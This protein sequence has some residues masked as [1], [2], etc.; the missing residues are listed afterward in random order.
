MPE[1]V[2]VNITEV[3]KVL[4]VRKKLAAKDFNDGGIPVYSS[5][6]Q[7]NGIKGYYTKAEFVIDKN[8]EN[9]NQYIVFGDHTRSINVVSTDFSV[10]DNVKVLVPKTE[11]VDLLYIKYAWQPKIPSLGYARHWSVAQSVN[12]D[13]PVDTDGN[14]DLEKQRDIAQKYKLI[15][16]KKETLLLKAEEA[17]DIDV[18]FD[19]DKNIKF[20]KVP[21]TKLFTPK[22]GSMKYSKK[23]CNEHTGKYPVYSGSTTDVFAHIDNVSYNGDYLTWVIDGLAGY[24]KRITG[25]FGITCHRGVLIPTDKCKNIDLDYVHYVI[26]PIFR[27]RIR[28]RIGIDGKNEYTALK[29]THIKNYNDSIP[30]PVKSDGSYDLDKQKELALKYKTIEDIKESIYNKVVEITEIVIDV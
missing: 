23:W 8:K 18:V 20:D 29:P 28:G 26:E 7:N 30:I 6:T 15:Y 12:I 9:K 24:I 19:I 1:K 22:G 2:T 21:I 4:P 3:L 27:K 25:E 11:L 16:E 13:I 14:Y 5:E 17:K 10:T